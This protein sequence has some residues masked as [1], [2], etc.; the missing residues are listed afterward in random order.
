LAEFLPLALCMW[1]QYALVFA[2]TFIVDVVPFPLPPAVTVMVFFA[3]LFDINIWMVLVL[4]VAGSILGRFTLSVYIP[5]LSSK[6]FR[7]KKNAD[8]HFLVSKLERKSWKAQLVMFLYSLVPLPTTPLFIAA[9]MAGLKPVQVIPGFALGKIISDGAMLLLGDYAAKNTIDIIQGLV[10]WKSI[11][12]FS[13]G[14]LLVFALFFVDWRV[15]FEHK[16]LTL[17]FHI[18]K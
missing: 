7:P 17:H 14:L 9:G 16:K 15:L 13:F 10:S 11:A 6:L 1:W 12:G 4:G 5:H 18:W 3:I 2:G 8:V